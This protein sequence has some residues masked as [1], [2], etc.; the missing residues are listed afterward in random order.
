[1]TQDSLAELLGVSKQSVY[2]YERSGRVSLD[3]F[4]RLAGL[5]DDDLADREYKLTFQQDGETGSAD[6]RVT[7]LKRRVC[8]EFRSMGFDAVMTTAPFDIVASGD[9]RVF[10]AVSNDWR[11]LRDRLAVLEGISELVGGYA[12]CISDRKVKGETSV[13]SPEELAEIKTPR[14]LFKLLSS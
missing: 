6:R 1:M 9:E 11:R 8:S 2:R 5:F 13:L 12:V 4:G 10:S 14:E 3:V 7:L